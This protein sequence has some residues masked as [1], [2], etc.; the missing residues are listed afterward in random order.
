MLRLSKLKASDT[1][2]IPASGY[3][4]ADDQSNFSNDIFRIELC[5]PEKSHWSVIDIP[6]IFRTTEEGINTEEDKLLV[7]GNTG[8]GRRGRFIGTADVG[9]PP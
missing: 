5:G 7:N 4:R 6:R 3:P 8:Y 2:G 9:N 1:M